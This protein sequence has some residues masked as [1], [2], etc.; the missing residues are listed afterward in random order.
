MTRKV[1]YFYYFRGTLSAHVHLYKAWVD[2]A[3][4]N[5]IDLEMVT[6]LNWRTYLKEFSLVR[7]LK[8]DYFHIAPSVRENLFVFFYFGAICLFSDRVIVQLKKRSP[9]PFDKLKRIFGS[10]LFYIVELEGDFRAEFDFLK[11]HPYK[12]GFYDHLFESLPR[13]MASQ[14]EILSH[15]DH[16]F[17]VS[18]P[19]K[20][21]LQQRYP[22]LDLDEKVSLMP[23]TFEPS[24]MFFSHESRDEWRRRLKVEDRLVM[25]YIGNAY[26]SWQNVYRTIDIGLKL[27]RLAGINA[28]LLLL[29]NKEDHGIVGEFLSKL[30]AKEDDYLLLHARHDEMRFYLSA[31]DIGVILR[32]KHPMNEILCMPG[33]LVDYLACGLP[34]L[35]TNFMQELPPELSTKRYGIILNNMDDD[36]EVLSKIEE[37]VDG[38]PVNREEISDWARRRYST[39]VQIA[40]YVDA[41]TKLGRN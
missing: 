21:M 12:Q 14:R 31:A 25:A 32:H 26:Y 17:A 38:S 27:K 1:R 22:D 13:E 34:V 10:K 36:D 24:E 19:Y 23:V 7:R 37:F 28:F 8:S 5:G 29:V 41:L 20:K 40:S 18:L 33:K 39:E 16:V 30:G 9:V 6:F 4:R 15:A 35:T 3:R 11:E 2:A